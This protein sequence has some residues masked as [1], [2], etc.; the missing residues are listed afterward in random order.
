[1]PKVTRAA[2]AGLAVLALGGAAAAAHQSQSE[3]MR[4]SATL[5]ARAEV[6]PPTGVPA[7]ARGA[8]TGTLTP[9]ARPMLKW[10]LTYA[11]LTGPAVQ[12]HVHMGRPGQAGNVLIPLCGP[13]RSGVMGST[14]I[15]PAV[16]TAIRTG[17]AYVNV[18]T[19]RNAPGE[20]RGQ[21]SV[22]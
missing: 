12:A 21:I 11:G 14:R 5:S 7:G 19:Q 6:P 2:V 4:V 18:H 8:F 20:I 10:K 1:M 16:A 15:T 22:R 17:K 13:C 9:A 3:A